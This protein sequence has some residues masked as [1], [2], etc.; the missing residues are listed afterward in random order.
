[1]GS[2][3]ATVAWRI[4]ESRF[5]PSCAVDCGVISIS[6]VFFSWVI[7]GEEI[8]KNRF[9]RTEQFFFF[10]AEEMYAGGGDS[11]QNNNSGITGTVLI[12][13]RFVWP[14]G[15]RMVLLSGSFTR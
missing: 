7:S 8:G 13:T 5:I 1:M 2:S 12:P 4:P 15:G 10:R 3:A 6:V 11:G 9:E 14:N